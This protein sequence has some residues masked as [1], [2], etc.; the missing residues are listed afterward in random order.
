MSG[1]WEGRRGLVAVLAVAVVGIWGYVGYV[2]VAGLTAVD[3]SEVVVA[4]P[5]AVRNRAPRVDREAFTYAGHFRDPF[6]PAFHEEPGT[7]EALGDGAAEEEPPPEPEPPS[8][9]LLGVIDGTATVE[10]AAGSVAFVRRGDEVEGAQV[11]AVSEQ[12]LTL[13]RDGRTYEIPLR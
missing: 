3:E 9:R 1:S 13:H 7:A 10:T 8:V 2:L 12:G 6:L 11:T 5:E 4:R